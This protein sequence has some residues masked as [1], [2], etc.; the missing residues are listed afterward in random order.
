MTCQIKDSVNASIQRFE[1]YIEK[2]GERPQKQNG[3]HEEQLNVNNM[4]TKIGR[5]KPLKMFLATNK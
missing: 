4:K 5:I 3:Q 2:S 1:D